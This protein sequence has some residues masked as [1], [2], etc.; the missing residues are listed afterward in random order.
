MPLAG[1]PR[2]EERWK[3]KPWNNVTP[4]NCGSKKRSIFDDFK[5]EE[6]QLVTRDIEGIELVTGHGEDMQLVSRARGRA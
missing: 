6:T 3:E 4:A 5:N 1:F 2:G